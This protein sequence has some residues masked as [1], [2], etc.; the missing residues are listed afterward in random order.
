MAE[1]L[2][3]CCEPLQKYGHVCTFFFFVF[4]FLFFFFF[5]FFFFATGA[6]CLLL[7]LSD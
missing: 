4:F 1:Q 7:G 5:F 2:T 3:K 6:S